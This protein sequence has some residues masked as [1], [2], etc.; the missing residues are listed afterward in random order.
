MLDFRLVPGSTSGLNPSLH[1]IPPSFSLK[2]P[3]GH[4]LPLK[5]YRFFSSIFSQPQ[6]EDF[7]N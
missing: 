1:F 3:P 7:T 2:G 4:P 5:A 6:K